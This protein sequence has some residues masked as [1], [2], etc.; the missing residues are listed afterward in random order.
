M[1]EFWENTKNMLMNA[2]RRVI[3]GLIGCFLHHY[4]FRF[5]ALMA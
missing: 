5:S 2:V 1:T 4:T 3:K